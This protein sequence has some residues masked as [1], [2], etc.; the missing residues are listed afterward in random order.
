MKIKKYALTMIN[1]NGYTIKKDFN[2]IEKAKTFAKF[3][4]LE[5]FFA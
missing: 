5:A 2:S 1:S 4:P 3:Y